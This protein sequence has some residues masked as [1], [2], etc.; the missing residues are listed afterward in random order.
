M[1][2]VAM[3][4]LGMTFTTCING[5]GQNKFERSSGGYLRSMIIKDNIGRSPHLPRWEKKK[6]CREAYQHEGPP[7]SPLASTTTKA[8][9]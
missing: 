2:L 4:F 3:G 6:R 1:F 5:D 8:I 7:P 9:F